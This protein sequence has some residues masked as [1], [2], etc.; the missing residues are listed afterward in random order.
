MAKVSTSPF[1]SD[2][3]WNRPIPSNASYVPA[4]LGVLGAA[5]ND[6]EWMYAS[7]G[8]DPYFYR[9]VHQPNNY[10]A[11]NGGVYIT[12][13][14][15]RPDEPN[16][17]TSFLM[18]DG[19]TVREYNSFSRTGYGDDPYGYKPDGNDDNLYN[20]GFIGGHAGSGMSVIGGSIRQG[21]LESGNGINHALK[22]ELDW[23][24][25]FRNQNASDYQQETFRWPARNSDGNYTNGQGNPPAYG[26]NN[27]ALRIGSLLALPPDTSISDM[28]NYQGLSNYGAQIAQALK[29]YGAY[30]VDTSGNYRLYN[31]NYTASL[32]IEAGEE[33]DYFSQDN[34]YYNT[35]QF[36]TDM[37]IIYPQLYV[38][39][40]NNQ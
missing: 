23:A 35:T 24:V 6:R 13:D 3:I 12:D 2:S 38:V 8:D 16:G 10:D 39:D 21:T 36:F 18:P 32:C 31:G 25:L 7:G 27:P 19:Q 29:T 22:I 9:G 11:V 5:A 37:A 20:G 1:A 15:Y 4:N 28:Q 30:V 17:C 14:F 33:T 40:S 34:N 26:G